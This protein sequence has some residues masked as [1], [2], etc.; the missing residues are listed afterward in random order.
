MTQKRYQKQIAISQIGKA[1]QERLERSVVT[2]IGCGGLGS[3]ALTYLACAGIGTLRIIDNDIVEESNLNRQFLHTTDSVGM[4]KTESAAKRLK[5]INPCIRI[6]AIQQELTK[7]NVKTLLTGSDVVLSCL[8]HLS[9][10]LIA[11]AACIEMGIPMIEGGV[12]GFQGFL[13]VIEEPGQMLDRLGF[14]D[15]DGQEEPA[16][17]G[18][19]PG[20][21][22]TLQAAECIKWLLHLQS[23]SRKELLV[24]DLLD[25]RL[26]HIPLH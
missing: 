6:E 3:P 12:C 20:I 10:R 23:R 4:A 26:E 18:V 7:E 15:P 5:E 2:V 16:V 11:G 24:V 9:A 21:I 17:I 19:A 13:S 14:R 8:D 1:G 25:L 22:G